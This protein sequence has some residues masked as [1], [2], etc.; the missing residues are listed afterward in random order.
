M[1][2]AKNRSTAVWL[3]SK[4]RHKEAAMLIKVTKE[5]RLVDEATFLWF[6]SKVKTLRNDEVNG[7]VFYTEKD[8]VLIAMIVD[9]RKYIRK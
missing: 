3:R 5:F 9:G 8:L 4:K 2:R 6:L 1:V 7:S